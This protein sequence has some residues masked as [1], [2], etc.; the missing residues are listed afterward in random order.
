MFSTHLSFRSTVQT[1]EC[2]CLLLQLVAE[3]FQIN[4]TALS[5][6][7]LF[8][9]REIKIKLKCDTHSPIQFPLPKPFVL[10]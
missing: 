6:L 10:A 4:C 2:S 8:E 9:G 5:G 3:T 1:T 7:E